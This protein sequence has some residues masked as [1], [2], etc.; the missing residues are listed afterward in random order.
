VQVNP[1]T[2]RASEPARAKNEAD[3]GDRPRQKPTDFS[4]VPKGAKRAELLKNIERAPEIRPLFDEK[5]VEEKGFKGRAARYIMESNDLFVNMLYPAVEEMKAQLEAE[6]AAAPDLE[7]MRSLAKQNAERTII[8]KIGRAVVFALAKQLNKEW[9]QK[10]LEIASSPESLSM[11]A[12]DFGDAMQNAR[13]LI[14]RV[15]R[16][17]SQVMDEAAA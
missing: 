1:G 14:S 6:Y 5:E 11:A 10:S 13:R 4:I 2:G 12:D 8:V 15:L 7:V 3:G 17:R 16:T 9:D